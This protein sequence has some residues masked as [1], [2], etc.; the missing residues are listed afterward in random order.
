MLHLK[1]VDDAAQNGPKTKK[2]DFWQFWPIRN[3]LYI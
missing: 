1:A 3:G 2:T